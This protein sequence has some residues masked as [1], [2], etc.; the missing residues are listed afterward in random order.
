MEKTDA[1]VRR[2]KERIRTEFLC[3]LKEKPVRQITVKELCQRCQINRTTFYK[4]FSD[5]YDVLDKLEQEA[6][7][8]HR[9]RMHAHLPGDLST[10]YREMLTDVQGYGSIYSALVSR[11]G[12]PEFFRKLLTENSEVVYPL[13]ERHFP[14]LSDWQREMLYQYFTYGSS[15]VIAGWIAGGM[16]QSVDKVVRFLD[17]MNR[18][19]ATGVVG[20]IEEA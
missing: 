17:Q 3:L 10:L 4:Y 12:D 14:A 5:P 18:S 2:S 20:G 9:E 8:Y 7:A 19:L 15:G 16:T 6:L 11:N 1:R 13:I